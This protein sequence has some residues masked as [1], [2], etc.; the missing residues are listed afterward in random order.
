MNSLFNHWE[1]SDWNVMQYICKDILN[2]ELDIESKKKSEEILFIYLDGR[3][4]SYNF[5]EDWAAFKST[6][7]YSEYNYQTWAFLNENV[8][9]FLDKKTIKDYR[10]TFIPIKP[11]NS[12]TEYSKFIVNN[13]YNLIPNNF[14]Y[15]CFYQSDGF[16]MRCGW[17]KYCIDNDFAFIGAHFQHNPAI[18][19]VNNGKWENILNFYTYGFNGGFSFRKLNI[20]KKFSELYGNLEQR[21]M[22][23]ENKWPQEDL[24]TGYWVYGTEMAKMPTKNQACIF[25]KDPCSL[26]MIK[27]RASFGFHRC[28]DKNKYL[29]TEH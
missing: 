2:Q 4:R 10:I 17:E 22:F 23:T 27:N 19:I 25:S 8:I 12:L 26:N 20:M 11:L 13:L 16:L 5:L 24:Q 15:L 28:V 9:D 21:E 1:K 29:C 3:L 14:K 6:K 18:E 7:L